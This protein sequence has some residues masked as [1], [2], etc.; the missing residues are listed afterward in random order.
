MTFEEAKTKI[1]ASINKIYDRLNKTVIDYA[2][3][4][5][6]KLSR[7]YITG[8]TYPFGAIVSYNNY[9]YIS[10]IPSNSNSIDDETSWKK[11]SFKYNQVNDVIK[12]SFNNNYDIINVENEYYFVEFLNDSDV[13]TKDELLNQY[14]FV[15]RIHIANLDKKS[16]TFTPFSNIGTSMFRCFEIERGADYIDVII[17]SDNALDDTDKTLSGEKGVYCRI[18]DIMKEV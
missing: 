5:G 16:I 1:T 15:C 12:I 18:T 4:S 17:R 6:L 10:K 11:I 2:L 13:Y 3:N 9:I 14:G 8:Y 7:K